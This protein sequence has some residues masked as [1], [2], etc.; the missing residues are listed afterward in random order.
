MI[1]ITTQNILTNWLKAYQKQWL[2]DPSKYRVW[3]KARQIGATDVGIAL[4][5]LL[6]ALDYPHEIMILS[7][8]LEGAKDILRDIRKWIEVFETLGFKVKHSASATIITFSNGSRIKAYPA[9]AESVRGFR[10]S[11]YWDETAMA[12]NSL[13]LWTALSPVLSSNPRFRASFASTP[14]GKQGAFYQACQSPQWS[15][16]LTTIHD[17]VK[18]GLRRDIQDLKAN[19]LNFARE[20]ECSWEAGGSYYTH[21]DLISIQD[22]SSY[23][24]LAPLE[25]HV[26]Y[27]LG[28]DL[29]KVNDFT[30]IVL[31][32]VNHL[33]QS[34]KLIKT[35]QMKGLSYV[36]Q[37]E[38]IC[39]IARKHNVSLIALDSTKH[40]DTLDQLRSDLKEITI[41]G[42]VFTNQWKAKA[43]P[44]LKK[45]IEER[46]LE[47]DWDQNVKWDG[48]SFTQDKSRP[49]FNQLLDVKQGETSSG[50]VSYVSPRSTQGH[51]DLACALVL[52]AYHALSSAQAPLPVLSK[53]KSGRLKF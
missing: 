10:G 32:Q 11:V 43:F 39:D 19:S 42:Q 4:D 25:D 41:I 27:V 5:A 45:Y 31:I 18:Q 2:Q 21:E 24:I 47:A 37:R 17:A 49:C 35:W 7:Y 48:S 36:T 15:L 50:L 46:V 53:A 28:V 12:R 6:D 40:P 51:G 26:S 8:R 1:D 23:N 22:F 16:H 3:L 44:L 38:I 30:A 34:M 52:G 29:A 9:Q 13:E 14:Y 20:F 33:K